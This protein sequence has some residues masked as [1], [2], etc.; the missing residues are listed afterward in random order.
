MRGKRA[1]KKERLGDRKYG[2][3]LVNKFI[4]K[5]MQDG[6][7]SR[8]EWLV[9]TALESAATKAKLDPDKFLEEVVDKVKPALE[10][11]SR[12]VGGANY[13]V[14]TPVTPARQ[15]TLAIRWIVDYSRS[16][17]GKAYEKFLEEELSAAF[18]GEGDAIKKKMDVERMAEANKA[19]AHFRW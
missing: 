10:I 16:K 13:A 15:D 1:S 8:A 5:V 2:S 19:F 3:K 7:K 11:R 6:K 17:S 14:P 4:N 9:Y 12:R 18:K